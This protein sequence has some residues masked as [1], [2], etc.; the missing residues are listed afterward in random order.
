[1]AATRVN[2]RN[3]GHKYK[4]TKQNSIYLEFATICQS[5]YVSR[6][7]KKYTRRFTGGQPKDG[8]DKVND[9][10]NHHISV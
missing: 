3:N 10:Q 5:I 6:G 1:M 8:S 9:N 2:R 4:E 7:N